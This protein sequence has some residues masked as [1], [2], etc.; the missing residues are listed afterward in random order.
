VANG[1]VGPQRRLQN[2]LGLA[3][4]GDGSSLVCA[5]RWAG[6]SA[7]VRMREGESEWGSRSFKWPR[8]GCLWAR[9]VT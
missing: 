5:R 2:E 4:N 9:C 3:V 7:D 8:V 1:L 6:G